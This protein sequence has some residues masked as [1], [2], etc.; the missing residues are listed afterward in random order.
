ETAHREPPASGC[1]MTTLA[2]LSSGAPASTSAASDP[3]AV[4]SVGAS[5]A[6]PDPASE[7]TGCPSVAPGCPSAEVVPEAFRPDSNDS[8][9][10]QAPSAKAARAMAARAGIASVRAS[11]S[12]ITTLPLGTPQDQWR[13]GHA[14]V[15]RFAGPRHGCRDDRRT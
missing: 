10:R 3:V 14:N 12:N 15:H 11:F 9:L 7:E 13:F 5:E 2:S 1:T 8:L 4:R 6:A